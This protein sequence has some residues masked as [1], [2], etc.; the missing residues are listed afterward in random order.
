MKPKSALLA[1]AAAS[2]LAACGGGG[3]APTDADPSELMQ[4]G[5][6]DEAVEI[7][8]ARLAQVEK[9]TADE[10]DLVLDHAKALSQVDPAKA[11]KI[12]VDFAQANAELVT[13]RDFK[14]V[15]SYLR[16]EGAFAEA[17]DVMH[18][19]KQRWP[20]DKEMV[21]LLELIK[22]DVLKAKDPALAAKMKGL[23]YM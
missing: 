22:A 12:F 15:V 19:G 16:T 1:F 8:E 7:I 23:G 4:Q 10:H 3:S 17:I 2:L 9:G 13:P 5:R 20:E 11:E 18:A 21:E 6:P 14:V